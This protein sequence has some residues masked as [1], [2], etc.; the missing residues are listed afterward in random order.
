MSKLE[1][2]LQ[3][4]SSKPKTFKYSELRT[5]LLGL[6][7]GKIKKGKTSGSRVAFY[8]EKTK[9]IFRLHRPHPGN[10][11]KKYQINLIIEE[12][13]EQGIIK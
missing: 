8:N 13:K 5:L 4:I 7:Y 1:K 11:L 6:G 2:L 10:E 12:L 9:H 3:K